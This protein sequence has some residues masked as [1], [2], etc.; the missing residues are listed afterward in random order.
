MNEMMGMIAIEEDLAR[1]HRMSMLVA[2]WL[3]FEELK[4][5]LYLNE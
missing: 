4:A 5:Q 2:L 3:Y 1:G